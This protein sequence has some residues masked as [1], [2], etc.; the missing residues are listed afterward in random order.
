MCRN[1]PYKVC[2]LSAADV[3]MG[4]VSLRTDD[5]YLGLAANFAVIHSSL[6]WNGST[7]GRCCTCVALQEF[8]V[9][10]TANRGHLLHRGPPVSSLALVWFVS[11]SQ[12]VRQECLSAVDCVASFGPFSLCFFHRAFLSELRQLQRTFKAILAGDQMKESLISPIPMRI[13][14]FFSF[15]YN[16]PSSKQLASLAQ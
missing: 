9:C 7:C 13:Y 10:V 16:Q 4:V 8:D 12:V 3:D 15:F 14:F 6:S 1:R 11:S 2:S 5:C